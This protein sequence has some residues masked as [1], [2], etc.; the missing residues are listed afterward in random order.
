MKTFK[1]YLIEQKDSW[2]NV[3]VKEIN[4][5]TKTFLQELLKFLDIIFNFFENK[6]ET[7]EVYN[8]FKKEI[9]P[10]LKYKYAEYIKK[11][12]DTTDKDILEIQK[13]KQIKDSSLIDAYNKVEKQFFKGEVNETD[14]LMLST[15]NKKISLKNK[16]ETT[17]ISKYNPF[18]VEPE[19]IFLTN[20]LLKSGFNKKDL[21][22]LISKNLETYKY[23]YLK[24]PKNKEKDIQY[25]IYF[26]QELT[27]INDSVSISNKTY[28]IYSDFLFRESKDWSKLK[29]TVEDYL[30]NNNKKLIPSIIEELNKFPELNKINNKLIKKT[31][32][33]YRGVGGNGL[34]EKDVIKQEKK[35]KYV[36]T[37]L[38]KYAAKNFAYGIGHLEKQ[39]QRRNKDSYIITYQTNPNNIILDTRIFGSVFGENE[40]LIN[41]SKAK[42]KNIERI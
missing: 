14:L 41:T 33:V 22:S 5:Q 37:S 16:K 28:Q 20:N 31:K 10:Y 9:D 26:I 12:I 29:K 21:T 34:K 15:L 8:N 25:L 42:I 7:I 3:Q 11:Y 24:F 18:K 40:V 17:A 38:S 2:L 6:E 30:L 4:K 13:S 27:R 36:A 23:S 35:N 32:E 39:D 1:E 19:Y